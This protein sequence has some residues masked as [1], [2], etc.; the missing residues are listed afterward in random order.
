MRKLKITMLVCTAVAL[1]AGVGGHAV[2]DGDPVG[3]VGK[4]RE[5]VSRK[6]YDTLIAQCGYAGDGAARRACESRV[7]ESYRVGRA[8]PGLDCRRYSGVT[9]CG[10]LEL[11]RTE[12]ACVADS[13]SK[14]LSRRRAEVECYVAY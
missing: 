4:P 9:V 14:G 7:E 11:T 13:V 10:T 1:F 2:A 8:N 6:Q 12:R 3:P 5:Q